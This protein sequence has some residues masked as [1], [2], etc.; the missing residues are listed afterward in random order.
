MHEWITINLFAVLFDMNV[1]G[2]AAGE[3]DELGGGPGVDA[4]LIPD[5]QF[6]L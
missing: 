3:F 1:A 6:P 4:Q 2:I 5:R